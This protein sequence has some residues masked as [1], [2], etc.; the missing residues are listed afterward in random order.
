[1]CACILP[2]LVEFWTEPFEQQY[3]TALAANIGTTTQDGSTRLLPLRHTLADADL[4]IEVI[5]FPLLFHVVDDTPEQPDLL[6]SWFGATDENAST[7]R[8]GSGAV[9]GTFWQKL[10]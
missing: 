6:D 9:V 1:M 3:E 10:L 8:G 2:L 4:E 7:M 5:D